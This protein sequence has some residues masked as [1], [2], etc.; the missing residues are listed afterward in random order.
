MRFNNISFPHP[1]MGISDDISGDISINP[2]IV[3]GLDNYDIYIEFFFDNYDIDLLIQGYQAEFICEVTCSDTLYRK[4][5]KSPKPIIE[6]CISR[7][8]VK[9]RVDFTCLV[10]SRQ[11]ISN[12]S[13]AASH[14]DYR[15]F[16]FDID[17]GEVLAYFGEFWFNADIRYEKLKAVSSFMDI[18]EN[19]ES[20]YTNIDLKKNKIEVQLPTLDYKIFS[21]DSIGKESKYASGFHSSIVLNALIIALYNFE[22]H[23]EEY[24]WAKV[25]DYRLKN[26]KE[27]ESLSIAEKENIPEIAQRLL[28]NP[29]HRFL[30]TLVII[31][32]SSKED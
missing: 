5:I 23:K 7:K 1:V 32:N 18:V 22:D 28:G 25:I 13:N 26:E 16:N 27:F 31:V 30:E 11:F 21:S 17:P 3:S 29:F 12:Y 24:R 14:I 10:V 9:G 19:K 20:E 6:L 4:I 15:G 8:E 2:R